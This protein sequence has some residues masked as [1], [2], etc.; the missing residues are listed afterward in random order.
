M[1][2]NPK[3]GGGNRNSTP[4][5]TLLGKVPRG[6]GR[7]LL[8]PNSVPQ[9]RRGQPPLHPGRH[10]PRGT[11]RGFGGGLLPLNN[12]MFFLFLRFSIPMIQR[13][14]HPLKHHRLTL[15]NCNVP[16]SPRPGPLTSSNFYRS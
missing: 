14:P 13:D 6:S 7:S 4:G 1:G 15:S 16:P 2:P 11:P 8:P 5:L 12:P 10:P 3:G 9:A